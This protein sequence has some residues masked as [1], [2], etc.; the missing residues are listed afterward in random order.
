MINKIRDVFGFEEREITKG[1]R[2]NLLLSMEL[3]FTSRCN[4]SCIYCYAGKDLFRK[5]EL[6]LDEMLDVISQGKALG[7]KKIIYVGAGEPLLDTK[8]CRVIE[9]AHKLGLEHIL[10][11][12]ATLLDSK[13]AHFF[14][15]HKLT[16][17]VKYTS[18]KA[19]VHDLLSGTTGAYQSMKR[20][21]EFLF[22]VGYPDK[23]HVLGVE[24]IICK[25]NVNE[26][27]SIWKWARDNNILPY[28]EYITQTGLAKDRGDMF[29]T[30]K[31]ARQ[32]FEELSKIDA[33]KYGHSW[34]PHPPIAGFSCKRHLYSCIINSQGFVQPCV[35][36][37]IKMGNIR[38][39][40]L[41]NILRNSNVRKKL[42]KIKETIKGPCKTCNLKAD[43][44]GCR[45]TAYSLT[46]DYLASD[47]SCWKVAE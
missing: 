22:E 14:Y 47:P 28:I 35:G 20:G 3:E 30:N 31:E 19:E 11:T 16:V 21:L 43:C 7:V 4:L 29:L 45:G 1:L 12:N 42:V 27:S 18:Q 8:L 9:Y 38:E 37:D 33:E 6:E 26:I 15:D 34:K 10:F 40:K 2:E 46:G 36:I 5:N 13:L 17:V 44:Y 32:V 41:A 23:E 24:A 39:E 25:Q